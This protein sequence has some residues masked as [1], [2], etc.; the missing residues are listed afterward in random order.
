MKVRRNEYIDPSEGLRAASMRPKLIMAAV[1]GLLIT[2]AIVIHAKELPAD[3]IRVLPLYV[4]LFVM[5]LQTN[6]SRYAFLVGGINSMLYAVVYF[7]IGLY[8][9]AVSALAVS[10]PLQIVSFIRW[11]R[12]RYGR[13]T[14]FRRLGARRFALCVAGLAAAYGVTYLIFSALGSRHLLLDNSVLIINSFVT[15]LSMLAYIEYL[16]LQ[17]VVQGINLWLYLSISL[18]TPARSPFLIYTVFSTVCA[19]LTFIRIQGLYRQQQ[20]EAS[21]LSAAG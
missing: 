11:G 10:F 12:H 20:R 16:Y 14:V 15:V 17:F 19:V 18:E 3:V 7:S 1:T 4:S 6:A 5:L 2:A 9:S 13:S 21:D 8:A